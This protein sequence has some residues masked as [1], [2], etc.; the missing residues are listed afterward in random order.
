MIRIPLCFKV[1]ENA[2]CK[3]GVGVWQGVGWGWEC[4]RGGV[5]WGWECGRGGVGGGSMAGVGWGVGVWVGA[6]GFGGGGLK[7]WES[8][9]F[10]G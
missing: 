10:S 7:F 9:L 4:G 8:A 6:E 5:G 1:I 2:R 3:G